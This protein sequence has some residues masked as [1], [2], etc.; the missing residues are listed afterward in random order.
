MKIHL[1]V[2]LLLVTISNVEL[3][4]Q[5]FTTRLGDSR[6]SA[7]EAT[8][9]AFSPSSRE[10]AVCTAKKTVFVDPNSGDITGSLQVSPL[11]LA[12][13]KDGSRI[14]IVAPRGFFWLDAKTKGDLN[15]QL[16][17]EPGFIGLALVEKNG[18]LIVSE[19]HDGGPAKANGKISIGDEI[20]GIGNGKNGRIESVIGANQTKAV[21]LIKGNIGEAVR[22]TIIPN[23]EIDEVT[24][25]VMRQARKIE[26]GKYVFHSPAKRELDDRVGVSFENNYHMFTHAK[27]AKFVS[28]IQTQYVENSR[29]SAGL[30]SDGSIYVFASKYVTLPEEFKPIPEPKKK[31][32]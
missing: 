10:V 30:S 20:I 21:S 29:G 4:G 23:G 18:K 8:I 11:S 6:Y 31:N 27:D 26:N 19:L 28:K 24:H 16:S 13:S 2:M 14:H 32:E 9:V 22:S 17:D 1:P 5:H 12:Y 3:L 25:I 7:P 15:F